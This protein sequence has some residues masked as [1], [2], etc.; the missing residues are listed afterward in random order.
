MQHR[1]YHDNFTAFPFCIRVA[2]ANPLATLQ[3][4]IFRNPGLLLCRTVSEK[5]PG[6]ET[7]RRKR[8]S[9]PAANENEGTRVEMQSIKLEQLWPSQAFRFE[10]VQQGSALA[11]G[12]RLR[13]AGK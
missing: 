9:Y 5:K 1:R 11:N 13:T 6:V 12:Q 8:G 4:R 3:F 10:I 7:T 2:R